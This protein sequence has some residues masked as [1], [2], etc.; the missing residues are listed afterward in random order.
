METISL[1][2][3]ENYKDESYDLPKSLVEVWAK[4]EDHEFSCKKDIF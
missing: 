2:K 1:E 3:T 4:T